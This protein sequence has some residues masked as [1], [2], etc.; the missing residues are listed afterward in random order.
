MGSI[1]APPS[2]TLSTL[3]SEDLVEVKVQK[4]EV[5]WRDAQR[6]NSIDSNLD[7]I[8]AAIAQLRFLKVVGNTPALLISEVLE[9][10]VDRYFENWLPLVSEFLESPDCHNSLNCYLQPPLDCAWIWHCH[11]LSPVKYAND[12]EQIFKKLLD[13]KA[14]PGNEPPDSKL[15][16]WADN[17]SRKRWQTAYPDEPYDFVQPCEDGN[18]PEFQELLEKKRSNRINPGR[19]RYDLVAAAHRQ[20][21]FIYQV[22]ARWFWDQRFLET[23]L[24]RYKGFLYLIKRNEEIQ[25]QPKG[26]FVP[27]YDID[28]L[29]HSHQL[30]PSAYNSDMKIF[31]GRVL[32]HDDT[33]ND[34]SIGAKLSVGFDETSDAWLKTYGKVYEQAG[35]MYRGSAPTPAPPIPLLTEEYENQLLSLTKRSQ[36]NPNPYNNNLLIER[37]TLKLDEADA[38]TIVQVNLV[39]LSAKNVQKSS[40]PTTINQCYV[41]VTALARC[42]IL[43]IRTAMIQFEKQYD[44]VEWNEGLCLE[45]DSATQ[46]LRLHL[47]RS[48]FR[49]RPSEKKAPSSSAGNPFTC[50]GG[51]KSV[52]KSV[53]AEEM[54]EQVILDPFGMDEVIGQ[55]DISWSELLK[56]K[57]G[58]AQTKNV[59]I[60]VVRYGPQ[61]SAP[62]PYL[63]YHVS[64]TPPVAAPRLFRFIQS[65]VTDDNCQIVT[66]RLKDAPPDRE[67]MIV[68]PQPG[69]WITKLVVNHVGSEK[70]VVRT[71]SDE[72]GSGK[73]R[74]MRP[75]TVIHVHNGSYKTF[76]Q[77]RI[78]GSARELMD[79]E[80]RVPNKDPFSVRY[81]SLFDDGGIL[82]VNRPTASKPIKLKIYGELGSYRIRLIPGARL[83]FE[84]QNDSETTS[85]ITLVRYTPDYPHGVATALINLRTAAIAVMPGES[86]V[87]VLLI[88]S[89]V[90]RSFYDFDT[91]LA[92]DPSINWRVQSTALPKLGTSIDSENGGSMGSVVLHNKGL[93]RRW[94]M[95][96]PREER[97]KLL[98]DRWKVYGGHE[99]AG[100][101]CS[102]AGCGGTA[103]GGNTCGTVSGGACGANY[104]PARAGHV[105]YSDLGGSSFVN[106]FGH[107]GR[108]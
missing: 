51:A 49:L 2:P 91:K 79:P 9:R 74:E 69:R 100:T 21:P 12:C 61:S 77:G 81:W 4:P 24:R 15:R 67:K 104:S 71:R 48:K 7:L 45:M 8:S 25:G 16:E 103:C 101:L 58:L 62:L 102:A 87:L 42:P 106:G 84:E 105:Q 46:G 35:A 32:D 50:F 43:D 90:Y 92:I 27:T 10:A 55:L 73:S 96:Y 98:Y 22:S 3:S 14:L 76:K 34:R 63:R 37:G 86:V 65:P 93:S 80:F 40:D 18:S 29:W 17:F 39:I 75:E 52:K 26:F 28:L 72:E 20:G 5:E 36:W 53:E 70:F 94:M 38:R 6:V 107:E 89:C 83:Q 99:M 54:P 13:V 85:C 31:L 78:L 33:V 64:I 30:A 11:K 57:S 95:M 1:R 41:R 108:G 97:P 19:L 44:A 60:Q 56:S 68:V 82:A 88:S 23:A 66:P 59:P 47:M